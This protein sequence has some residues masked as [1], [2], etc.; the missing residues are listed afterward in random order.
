MDNT[1]TQ[2]EGGEQPLLLQL[3]SI[4]IRRFRSL[5]DVG[6]LPVQSA[7]TVLTGENDGGK[8]SCLDAV[9]FLLENRSLDD[10]DRSRWAHD[11]EPIEVE[12]T[13][14]ALDDTGCIAP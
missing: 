4:T 6:P 8:T 12:G 7:L 5:H 1:Q 9:A 14:C 10:D 3:R 13:F 11:D 2:R